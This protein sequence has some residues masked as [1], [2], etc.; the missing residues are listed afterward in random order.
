MSWQRRALSAPAEVKSHNQDANESGQT[1]STIEQS[2]LCPVTLKSRVLQDLQKE[3]QQADLEPQYESHKLE[4]KA[5]QSQPS[6]P[7]LERPRAVF[8]LIIACLPVFVF[9]SLLVPPF[10][11]ELYYWCWSQ[12]LQFSYFDHPPMVAYL[13]RLSTSLFGHSILAIRVPSIVSALVVIAVVTWLSRPRSLIPYIILSPVPTFAAVMITPDVPLLMFW[14]LYIA[15]LVFIHKRL[16]GEGVS[17]FK[18]EPIIWHWILGGL[19][20]G[21]GVLGKYTTGL[22]VVSG[23]FSFVL[24][25]QWKRWIVGYTIQGLTALLVASPILIY[26]IQ[27][28]FAS[29]LFQWEHA[30]SSP[31][32]GLF[33]FMEFVGI[34]MLFYGTFPFLV[35]VW[36]LWQ[37]RTLIADPKLRVCSCLFLLP[38]GFFLYKATQG[39][40]EG[41]WAFPCYLACWPLVA[42]FYRSV[43][44]LQR[45]R[46]LSRAAFTP[47]L[48]FSVILLVHAI[49]PLPF[50]PVESDRSTRQ[51]DKMA[52]ARSVA[53][54]LRKVGYTGP[55]YAFT[56]QWVSLLRWYGVDAYQHDSQSRPSHFSERDH[57]A[58]DPAHYIILQETTTST[59]EPEHVKKGKFFVFSTHQLIVRDVPGPYFHLIDFSE[60][61]VL[62]GHSNCGKR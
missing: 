28:N 30:M 39:R 29:V 5:P 17:E 27:N 59:P 8:W 53:D 42:E 37:W 3:K 2:Q 24:A 26:N 62:S 57:P 43:A 12:E 11:D 56:Y 25:G 35:F 15:W 40:L 48:V 22:A 45:W 1:S 33:P 7:L 36:A 14:A 49:E 6:I 55:V 61:S 58:I 46:V 51:W 19:I 31:E 47:A 21:C 9:L 52:L 54:D 10:D 23:F 34:Q 60:T 13:I 38:F 4:T 32:P 44:H 20:I 16:W 41:N 50:I 18:H